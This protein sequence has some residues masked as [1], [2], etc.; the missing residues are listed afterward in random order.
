[1]R[2]VAVQR[3]YCGFHSYGFLKPKPSYTSV[4]AVVITGRKACGD[5]RWA[6]GTHLTGGAEHCRYLTLTKGT[7]NVKSRK[8]VT[9]YVTSSSKAF[10]NSKGY[11]TFGWPLLE[12]SLKANAI[13]SAKTRKHK[14]PA[15][16]K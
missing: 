13:L 5:C 4:K 2:N 10:S 12:K 3:H 11:G 8:I 1:M 15:S 6:E 16:C 7:G 14:L 9:R